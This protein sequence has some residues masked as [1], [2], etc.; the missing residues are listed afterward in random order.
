[1]R[2]RQKDAKS[3]ALPQFYLSACRGHFLTPDCAKNFK[4]TSCF[5]KQKRV[6]PSDLG[7][8]FSKPDPGCQTSKQQ[9]NFEMNFLRNSSSAAKAALV[10]A[11][12]LGL[13]GCLF[14]GGKAAVRPPHVRLDG[15]ANPDL[16]SGFAQF[17]G[18]TIASLP[19]PGGKNICYSPLS[20][21]MALAL[22]GPGLGSADLVKLSGAM[23]M[24]TE[25]LS[26]SNTFAD[27]MSDSSQRGIVIAN[28]LWT[29]PGYSLIPD[30]QSAVKI[31]QD[32]EAIGLNSLGSAGANQI[33]SWTADHTKN[34]I[35]HL[36][37][38]LGD[39]TRLVLVN[40][41][42]FDGEWVN[43]FDPI[44]TKDEP[45][46]ALDGTQSS[47]KTMNG[48]FTI[49]CAQL[50]DGQVGRFLYK[51][52]GCAM[53]IILP[54]EGTDPWDALTQNRDALFANKGLTFTPSRRKISLPKFTMSSRLTLTSMLDSLGLGSFSKELTGQKMVNTS[55][56]LNISDIL[57]S[58]WIETSEKGTKAAAATAIVIRATA[59]RVEPKDL[60]EFKV[61]R[62]FAYIVRDLKSGAILFT[63]AVYSPQTGKDDSSD[64]KG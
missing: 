60:P 57:Q 8:S 31:Q 53:D 20:F 11:A 49:E 63:G 62:P 25:A 52:S 16:T 55:Q 27:L 59:I 10:C 18:S 47:V 19:N 50:P 6:L 24:S 33:N 28:S 7:S 15:G 42:T 9:A 14:A 3:F 32:G 54:A 34:R 2:H 40:A 38:S 36:M 37:D 58:D 22:L 13:G 5:F 12:G 45:F 23:G 43:P 64:S 26:K 17:A 48:T 44:N 51:K 30:Y 29:A 61:D 21:Q 39:S 41:L 56:P 35:T 46:H 4:Y 1:M